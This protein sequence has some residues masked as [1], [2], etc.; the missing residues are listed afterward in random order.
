[1]VSIRP[2]SPATPRFGMTMPAKDDRERYELETVHDL[3]DELRN[4]QQDLPP[5][6]EHESPLIDAAQILQK[7]KNKGFKRTLKT[8]L[9]GFAQPYLP[10]ELLKLLYNLKQLDYS[11]PHSILKPILKVY[12]KKLESGEH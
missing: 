1:M 9:T 2:F 7:S 3:L 5:Q 12:R 10:N 11:V 4:I 6:P 8:A